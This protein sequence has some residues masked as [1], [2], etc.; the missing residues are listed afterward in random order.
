VIEIDVVEDSTD[1]KLFL[2]WLQQKIK[3]FLEI[4]RK[5][6]K[7][8]VGNR[9]DSILSQAMYFGLAF[10][11]VGLDFRVLMVPLFEEAVLDQVRK[12]LDIG[13]LKFDD[14]LAKVNWSELYLENSKDLVNSFEKEFVQ[15][16][17][18]HFLM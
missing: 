18:V 16:K 2:C 9:I 10:S 8:G 7:L 15:Q 13:Q 6:L 1:S 5:D 4:L 14:S 12:Y 3:I 17:E 11:R